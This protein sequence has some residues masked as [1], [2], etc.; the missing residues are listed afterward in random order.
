MDGR[1]LVFDSFECA[2]AA[3]APVCPHCGRRV[4]GHGV[5]HGDT[6]YAASTAPSMKAS[7]ASSTGIDAHF[8]QCWTGFTTAMTLV[9]TTPSTFGSSSSTTLVPS[10]D[11][12]QSSCATSLS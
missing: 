5:Q 10:S 4:I 8:H 6:I 12:E 1:T 2:I 7:R 3:L 11:V 9:C